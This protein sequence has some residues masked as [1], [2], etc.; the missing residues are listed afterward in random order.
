VVCFRLRF[1]VGASGLGPGLRVP[2]LRFQGFR[3]DG[4][5]GRGKTLRKE[6][7]SLSTL[8]GSSS[9]IYKSQPP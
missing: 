6:P 1:H 5:I 9:N 2:G 8:Y 4:L 7:A 3:V